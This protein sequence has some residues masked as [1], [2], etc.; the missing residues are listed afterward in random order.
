MTIWSEL[1]SITVTFIYRKSNIQIG[2]KI[3]VVCKCAHSATCHVENLFIFFQSSVSYSNIVANNPVYPPGKHWIT[4]SIERFLEIA[5]TW[6]LMNDEML[7]RRQRAT[8]RWN[9]VYRGRG[10]SGLPYCTVNNNLKASGILTV[11]N[12]LFENVIQQLKSLDC[13]VTTKKFS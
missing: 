3:S 5:P 2:N 9:A 7:G 13:N 12:C 1:V 6:I 10:M 8:F 4:A 11:T